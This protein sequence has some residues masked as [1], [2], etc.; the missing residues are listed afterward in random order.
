M[1][2]AHLNYDRALSHMEQVTEFPGLVSLPVPVM[3]QHLVG[4][5]KYRNEN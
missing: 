4:I 2:S 3:A 5:I 1:D